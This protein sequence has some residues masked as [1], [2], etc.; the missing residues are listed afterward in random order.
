LLVAAVIAACES[1]PD[2]GFLGGGSGPGG[3]GAP[4]SSQRTELALAAEDELEATEAAM[5]LVAPGQPPGWRQTGCP[6]A[7]ISL[8]TDGDTIPDD[9]TLTF[10]NPPCDSV[11]FRGGSFA[12]TGTLRIQDSTAADTFSYRLTSTNLAWAAT[13]STGGTRS[14][15]ATRNGTRS[16]T[17]TD[18]SV[19]LNSTVTIVR[20][21]PS[22]SDATITLT[23]Q[24]EF[25]PDTV[26]TVFLGRSLPIGS[27]NMSGTFHWKRSTE[28][29]TLTIATPVPLVLDPTCTTT[30]Q[31]LT[32]GKLTLSGVVAGTNG[33]LTLTF[34]G[35]GTDPTTSWA[36]SP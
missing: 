23:S 33:V 3:S 8:D 21:R 20:Q 15:T 10:S 25:F 7:G 31:R 22:R 29:W 11:G 5:S 4:S 9:L 1:E 24:S 18:S 19:L 6:S 26:G 12:V 14:F 16:R 17:A 27:L 35:C 32:S 34:N 2:G 13:D 28:D 36:S 30:P